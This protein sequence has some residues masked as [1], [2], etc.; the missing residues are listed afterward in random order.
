MSGPPSSPEERSRGSMPPG[1]PHGP[2][3][4]SYPG[5]SGQPPPIPPP[6]GAPL[7]PPPGVTSAPG[8][9]LIQPGRQAPVRE[10]RVGELLDTGI[11]LYRQ[12]WKTFMG[13]VA[14]V[15][16][17]YLFLQAFLAR[18]AIST[19]PFDPNSVSAQSTEAAQRAALIGGVFSVVFLLFVQ[20]ILTGAVARAAADVYRGEKPTLKEM[21]RF[22]LSRLLSI[23]WVAILT[24]LAVLGGFILLVIPAI[25]F[26]VRFTFGTVV[27]VVEG[28][29]GRKALGRSWRLATG[30]FWKIF[31]TLLLAGILTTIVASILQ[32]P[33]TLAAI[34]LE[35]SGWPLRALGA[36][37]AAVI[38]RPF[39]A[40]VTVLLYFDSRIKKEGMDLE[41]MARDLGVVP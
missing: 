3:G 30:R 4:P 20:P 35:E 8:A 24:G 13:L 2:E 9:P 25:I 7:P 12:N 21:Y 14:V 28:E 22:G 27:L 38:T 37:G 39:S 5:P 17:P 26:G 19:N 34:P 1:P 36:A 18:G 29:R 10:M 32:I 15:L 41:V 23:L 16:V 40:L 33:L 31:G 6:P 11:K